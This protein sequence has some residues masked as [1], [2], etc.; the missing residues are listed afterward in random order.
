MILT[1]TQHH[2]RSTGPSTAVTWNTRSTDTSLWH[3]NLGWLLEREGPWLSSPCSLTSTRHKG[4]RR[5]T[6]LQLLPETCTNNLKPQPS[7]TAT[8]A[9]TF[10]SSTE[11][12]GVGQFAIQSLQLSQQSDPT[13]PLHTAYSR[14]DPMAQ[15]PSAHLAG[16]TQTKWFSSNSHLRLVLIA[17]GAS[18]CSLQKKRNK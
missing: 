13:W 6:E 5:N 12:T 4:G 8:A 9:D 15:E 14:E 2:L 16:D 17:S 3:E 18:L 10:Y 11:H 1:Y 7:C